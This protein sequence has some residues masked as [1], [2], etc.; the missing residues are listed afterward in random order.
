MRLRPLRTDMGD[1]LTLRWRAFPLRPA[2]DTTV[3][4]AGTHRE[5]AKRVALPGVD[6]DRLLA[7]CEAG[8]GRQAALAVGA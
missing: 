3:G 4:F 5:A 1:R 2:P 7:D 8:T 6:I